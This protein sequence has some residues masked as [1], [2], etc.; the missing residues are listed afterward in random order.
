M[1]VIVQR[2][3]RRKALG[4]WTEE[5]FSNNKQYLKVFGFHSESFFRQIPDL[6]FLPTHPPPLMKYWF[7]IESAL[8]SSAPQYFP[9]SNPVICNA[10]KPVLLTFVRA[11]DNSFFW[12]IKCFKDI[13]AT[14]SEVKFSLLQVSL[15]SFPH[16]WLAFFLSCPKVCV[17]VRLQKFVSLNHQKKE[18][19]TTVWRL[20]QKHTKWPQIVKSKCETHR[21]LFSLKFRVIS[22]SYSKKGG[23]AGRNSPPYEWEL[24]ISF[25]ALQ[26]A[27]NV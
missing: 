26:C 25:S 20:T 16:G 21:H 22:F 8:S 1:K 6:H 15:P 14:K 13:Q 17:R 27:K 18:Y 12:E 4:T 11:I 7:R 9:I 2:R 10:G 19:R 5:R 24:M 3:Q 23:C